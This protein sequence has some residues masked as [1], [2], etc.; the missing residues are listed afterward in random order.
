MI[1]IIKQTMRYWQERIVLIG[2]NKVPVKGI[3]SFLPPSTN[4]KFIRHENWYIIRLYNI[5]YNVLLSLG[6][7]NLLDKDLVLLDINSLAK[8]LCIMIYIAFLLDY[9]IIIRKTERM[10]MTKQKEK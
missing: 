8:L 4:L 3:P 10:L 7:D 5:S 2:M 6:R 9:Y 1:L